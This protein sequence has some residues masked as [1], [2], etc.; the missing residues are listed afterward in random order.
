[1]KRK[2]RIYVWGGIALAVL[3][4]AAQLLMRGGQEVAVVKVQTGSIN[5]TVTD[6]GYVQPASDFNIHATQTARV[7]QVVA[8]AGQPVKQGE[9]LVVLE[10]LDLSLQISDTQSQIAQAGN[11]AAGARAALERLNLELK[12]ASDNLNRI[13][14][15]FEGGAVSRADYDKAVL[16]VET[17]RQN[18]NEQSSKL[19]SALAQEAGLRQTLNQ[20]SAKEGQLVVKSPTDGMV[21]NLPVKQEEV[22]NSGALLAVLAAAGQLEVKA[23][24]LSDDLGEVRVG[25]KVSI[26]APV[27]GGKKLAG[28]VKKIYPSAEEKES[29]LGV[30]QRRVPVIITLPDPDVLK[31]GYEVRVAIETLTRENVLVLPR[32]AVRTTGDGLKEVMVVTQGQVQRRT[33]QTGLSDQ[34]NIEI[35][36]GLESGEM[37]VRDGGLD[38]KEKARVKPVEKS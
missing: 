2:R 29:A 6:S 23:D 4:V 5:R 11:T 16:L 1:M 32:E 15:L 30:I 10:N 12:D 13:Q 35:T 18:L 26:T 36:G 27:L 22:V 34:E 9:T 25:Q 31:P 33:V 24:I 17:C 38:L 19:D 3:A 21:L 28:A 20:L 14:E 37:I 7:T 8:E